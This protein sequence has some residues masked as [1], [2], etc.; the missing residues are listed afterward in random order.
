M[1]PDPADVRKPERAAGFAEDQAGDGAGRVG[2][3]FDGSRWN[4]LDQRAAAIRRDRVDVDRRLA[5]VELV[6]HRHERRIA[7]ILVLVA[8]EEPYAVG[9]KRVERVLDFLEAA[10]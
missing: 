7:E 6:E 8:G 10:L 3:V 1:R 9:M 4:A 5:A 2:G